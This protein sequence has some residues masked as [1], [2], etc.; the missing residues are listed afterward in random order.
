[1]AF[2][3]RETEPLIQSDGGTKDEPTA[4]AQLGALVLAEE[5]SAL[6]SLVEAFGEFCKAWSKAHSR[7]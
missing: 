4:D 3:Y 5:G 1:M 7:R 6:L 2:Q